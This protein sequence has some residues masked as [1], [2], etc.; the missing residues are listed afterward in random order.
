ML[1]GNTCG[2]DFERPPD[3]VISEEV[4]ALIMGEQSKPDGFENKHLREREAEE[5]GSMTCTNAH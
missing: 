5:R 1:G 3:L 4:K 2:N